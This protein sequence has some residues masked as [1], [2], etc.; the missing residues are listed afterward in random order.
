MCI[1]DRD[2]GGSVGDED[3]PQAFRQRTKLSQHISFLK[4][5][6]RCY[7][8][9]SDRHIDAIEIMLGKLYAKFGISDHTD[10]RTLTAADYPI[11]SDLYAFIE[12][13][14]QGYDKTEYQ[15]YPSELLQ[16]ILLEMCIRDRE[17][18]LSFLDRIQVQMATAREFLIL[19]RLRDE[20]EKEVFPYLSRIEKSLKDQGFS[21]KRADLSLIHI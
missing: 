11:L 12:D 10:F 19:I 5:F 1:R 2:E 14:F 9:F 3:A 18:D 6:F 21:V 7:K 17:K 13:E 20:K 8:D 15:L 4:D 16:E